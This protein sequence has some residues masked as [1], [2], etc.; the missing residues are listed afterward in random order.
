MSRKSVLTIYAYRLQSYNI[1]LSYRE[2]FLQN[3][4]ENFVSVM[5]YGP[6]KNS[7]ETKYSTEKL[8]LIPLEHSEIHYSDG[9]SSTPRQDV[10]LED[11]LDSKI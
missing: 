5:T 8:K 6:S 4:I 10:I 9:I 2:F 1:Q 11:I 3:L 7:L